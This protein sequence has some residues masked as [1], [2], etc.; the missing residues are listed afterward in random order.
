MSFEIE[1]KIEVKRE[2]YL[3]WSFE[4]RKVTSDDSSTN[5]ELT[6]QTPLASVGIAPNSN[7]RTLMTLR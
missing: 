6:E 7:S 2:Q 1:C 5:P 3:I 4:M